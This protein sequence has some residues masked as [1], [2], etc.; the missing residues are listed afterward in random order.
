VRAAAGAHCSC[1]GRG[2]CKL[3]ADLLLVQNEGTVL[4]KH[5]LQPCI[6]VRVRLLQGARCSAAE[7]F[8][9][10]VQCADVA[11]PAA[12]LAGEGEGAAGARGQ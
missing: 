6:R 7:Q 11:G 3:E 2:L 10:A 12:T 8:C 1:I 9:S 5:D 4:A